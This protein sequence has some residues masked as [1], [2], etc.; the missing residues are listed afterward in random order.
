MACVAVHVPV[1]PNGKNMS[2]EQHWAKFG[3]VLVTP[4]PPWNRRNKWRNTD[5]LNNNRNKYGEHLHRCTCTLPQQWKVHLCIVH[6]TFQLH[7][8]KRMCSEL[9]NN[10]RI[11]P[12]WPKTQWLQ[13][14]GLWPYTVH[15]LKREISDNSSEYNKMREIL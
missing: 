15:K 7:M 10:D 1:K 11:R 13:M 3:S 4:A 9:K 14:H 5:L 12:M 6:R 2:Q 8:P